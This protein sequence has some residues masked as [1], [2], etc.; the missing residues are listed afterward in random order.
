MPGRL[1]LKI[2]LWFWMAM[3]LLCAIVWGVSRWFSPVTETAWWETVTAAFLHSVAVR[4]LSV[5]SDEADE[6]ERMLL[7]LRENGP[8]TWLMRDD[9]GIMPHKVPPREAVSAMEE[10]RASSNGWGYAPPFVARRIRWNGQEVIVTADFVRPPLFALALWQD[11]AWALLIV[12][13]CSGAICYL[14]ARYFGRPVFR[15]R[16]AAQQVS[17]GNLSVR[18]AQEFADRRDEL[19]DL[20]LTFDHMVSQVESLLRSQRLLLADVSHEIRS[21]LTRVRLALELMKGERDPSAERMAL[22]RVEREIARVDQILSRL[23]R[24]TRLETGMGTPATRLVRLD[25]IVVNTVSDLRFEVG[26][27]RAGDLQIIRL[28]PVRVVGEASL[29]RSAVENLVRNALQYTVAGSSVLVSLDAG[30]DS[31]GI[32]A[33]LRVEDFGPGVPET[34]LETIFEP[35][36]RINRPGIS[37][38]GT[39]LGLSI[40]RRITLLHG[41]EISA[42]NR[43]IGGLEVVLQL[44]AVGILS[45][46]F[47]SPF[48]PVLE[49]SRS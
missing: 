48:Q 4:S 44:P 46:T 47:D 33:F 9:L 22:E 10:A 27:D 43:I 13:G 25:R 21:P 36:H 7:D 26:E 28:T 12:L 34:D 35:F 30:T 5:P 16:W 19:A 42:R 14:L 40:A 41:G 23:L 37:T 2:F 11:Q 31:R 3:L 39:G 17:E 32:I 24:L 15:L 49:S 6:L 38:S 8:T 45:D 29:L 18:L 1:F 20:A